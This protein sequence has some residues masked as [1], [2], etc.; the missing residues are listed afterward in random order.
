MGLYHAAQ[1]RMAPTTSHSSLSVQLRRYQAHRHMAASHW[2]SSKTAV[3]QL[4]SRRQQSPS[5]PA[6]LKKS[7]FTIENIN[8][9]TEALIWL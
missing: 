9:K 7:I 6:K 8:R 4:T 5:P 3:S 2:P 1:P